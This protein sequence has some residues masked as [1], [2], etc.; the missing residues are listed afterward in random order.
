MSRTTE[1]ER[2]QALLATLRE[3]TSPVGL[4]IAAQA[5][6]GRL[7][8]QAEPAD[9]LAGLRA[10]RANAQAMAERALA[11]A[12]PVVARL[13]G[14]E[15]MAALARDLWREHPPLRGDLAWFGGELADWLAA[16]PELVDAPYLADVA[17]LE[18]A[19]HRAGSA[20]DPADAPPDLQCLAHTAPEAIAVRF[21]AGSTCI[22]SPWP[23]L[24]LW[25]AHQVPPDAS[26][27][28]LPVRVAM[29]AGQ[30]EA[31]WV[32]RRGHQ[33]EHAVL[34][35]GEAAFHLELMAGQTLGPAWAAT[36]DAHPDFSFEPWLV[37]ALREG[38][39]A[40]L[41]PISKD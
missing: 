34:T 5:L 19:M 16:S 30:G 41:M 13:V 15:T 17:R 8:S 4:P 12:Y 22:V 31:G 23:V 35:A 26:P 24:M 6:P 14:E 11:A 27:D 39:L 40:A 33:V 1:A 36:L 3:A 25:Q 7:P 32:W 10:Y 29:A 37:R 21:V 9:R 20:A 28:L 2:Q 38:W 18:W